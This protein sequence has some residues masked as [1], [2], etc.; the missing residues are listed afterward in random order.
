MN[1]LTLFHYSNENYDY[2]SELPSVLFLS[3]SKEKHSWDTWVTK[4]RPDV[5]YEYCYKVCLFSSVKLLSV[6][7]GD[8]IFPSI[9]DLKDKEVQGLLFVEEPGYE[10]IDIIKLYSHEFIASIDKTENILKRR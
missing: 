6:L 1:I 5:H 10:H 3:S 2:V 4:H 8:Y 7:D 9:E